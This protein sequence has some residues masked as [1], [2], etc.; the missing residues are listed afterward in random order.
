MPRRSDRRPAQLPL[1]LDGL[2]LESLDLEALPPLESLDLEGLIGRYAILEARYA[3][4]RARPG[5]AAQA[6]GLAREADRRL[7]V[8][9]GLAAADLAEALDRAARPEG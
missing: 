5:D 2:D 3:Q 9:L 7:Y 4:G 6:R 8:N 1:P